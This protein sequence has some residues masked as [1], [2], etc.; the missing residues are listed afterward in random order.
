[1]LEK[2]SQTTLTFKEPIKEI[3]QISVALNDTFVLLGT[4][5]LVHLDAKGNMLWRKHLDG[6]QNNSFGMLD[7]KNVIVV[8]RV[9]Q[10][11]AIVNLES[12]ECGSFNNS[13]LGNSQIDS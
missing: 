6:K 12:H 1:M 7:E 11:I 13:S 2:I 3:Y 9:N 10:Q 4:L 5:G 8:D